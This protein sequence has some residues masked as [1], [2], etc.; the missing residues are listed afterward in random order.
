MT[1][2]RADN[3]SNRFQMY[4][5]GPTGLGSRCALAL[6]CLSYFFVCLGYFISPIPLESIP[7]SQ[8]GRHRVGET[9][10]KPHIMNILFILFETKFQIFSRLREFSQLRESFLLLHSLLVLQYRVNPHIGEKT[11]GAQC[12]PLYASPLMVISVYHLQ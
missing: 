2:R 1:R 9:T 5:Q 12:A 3:P 4:N 11:E 6:V 8:I 7:Y 10:S